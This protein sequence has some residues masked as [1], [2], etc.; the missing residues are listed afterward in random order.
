LLAEKLERYRAERPIVLGLTRGGVPVALEVARSLGADLDVI[1]VRKI[2]APECP[3]Y[4]I[5]AIA[6]G[7]AVYVRREALPEVGLGDDDVAALA[8]HEAVELARRVRVYRG[9]RP[10]PDLAGRTVI[11]VDDGVATGATARAAARAAR[12]RGAAHVVLAAPVI[13]AGSKPDLRLD[14][15]DVVA[16]DFP[17]PFIAVGLWYERFGQVSDEEVLGCLRRS[18]EGLKAEREEFWNGEWIGPESGDPPSALEQETL[19]IPF[20][21][22]PFGPGVLD[23][24]L[25]LPVGAKGLVMFVHGS[26]STRHSPRNRLVARAMQHAGFATLLFDLLTPA[27]AAEDDVTAR[28]RFDIDLLTARVGAATR[29]VSALPRTRGLRLGYFGAST[30]AAAALAAAAESPELVAAVVSRGGRPDLVPAMTLERV[31]APVL[32]VVGSRDDEVLRLNRSVLPH[33]ATAELAVVPGATHLF[34]EPGALEAVARLAA[35]W[36]ARRLEEPTTIRRQP[37]V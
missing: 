8:E 4:A 9:D 34:E 1:V 29:W 14:F 33:L 31:R 16:V 37:A 6:E 35:E 18:R 19:A 24:D 26:G 17:E 3:E 27:E 28:L 15:D 2:G 22:S 10:M 12:Q 21:G 30:G 11:V 23:A 5:G 20:D 7:G 32:L 25:F 13:A 36:F